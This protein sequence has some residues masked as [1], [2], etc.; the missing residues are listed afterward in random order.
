MDAVA[1]RANSAGM[2]KS[3]PIAVTNS[4]K[5]YISMYESSSVNKDVFAS[6]LG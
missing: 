1:I 6:S 3:V 2:S 4:S 5:K